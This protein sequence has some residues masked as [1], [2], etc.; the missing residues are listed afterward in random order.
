MA[1]QL[2]NDND[3]VT[4]TVEQYHRMLRTGILSEGEPVELLN[5]LL[6]RKHR[7]QGM[8][9]NLLHALVVNR[10][11]KL[12]PALDAY[13]YH[14]RLQNP[15]TIPP[16]HEPEPDGAIVRGD[17][18]DYAHRHLGPEDVLCVIEVADSSL[19]HDRT[20]KQSI[21]AAAGISQYLIVNIGERCIE[22]Y[23][24]PDSDANRYSRVEV[25]REE[26]TLSLRFPD[27]QRLDIPAS[28]WLA[29]GI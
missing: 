14:L 15:I 11:M 21:Y 13:G 22:S 3:L 6:M 4:L 10:L 20:L 16:R 19:E 18:E 12:A 7:G 28:R 24:A 23:Q 26:D 25:L 2:L 17:I 5:G 1:T 27:S 29:W 8:A 9:V